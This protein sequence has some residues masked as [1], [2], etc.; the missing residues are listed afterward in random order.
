MVPCGY[1]EQKSD[2]NFKVLRW[3]IKNYK[4]YISI[5]VATNCSTIFTPF[6]PAPP[7][8]NRGALYSMNNTCSPLA[9]LFISLIFIFATKFIN[10]FFLSWSLYLSHCRRWLLFCLSSWC[11]W[12]LCAVVCIRLPLEIVLFSS[13]LSTSFSLSDLFFPLPLVSFSLSLNYFS[14]PPSQ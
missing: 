8:N 2:K 1:F 11:R 6:P 3:D 14:P 9:P 4:N 5:I 7:A 12:S 13:D 10:I